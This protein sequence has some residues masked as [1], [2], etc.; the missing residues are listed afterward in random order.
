MG[1]SRMLSLDE[2]V[3]LA[4]RHSGDL[5]AAATATGIP[6][7]TLNAYITRSPEYRLHLAG[8]RRGGVYKR[9]MVA[10]G[11]WR[12]VFCQACDGEGELLVGIVRKRCP[13]CGG[14]CTRQSQGA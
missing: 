7:G 3:E 14:L 9:H 12:G 4:R 13:K 10:Q 1:R 5:R 11:N 8:V 6:V 2:F